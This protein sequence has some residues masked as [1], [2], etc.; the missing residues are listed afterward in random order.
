M[1]NKQSTATKEKEVE[2]EL[3]R[4]RH[5]LTLINSTHEYY[6]GYG[7]NLQINWSGDTHQAPQTDIIQPGQS[8]TRKS[9]RTN[10]A[11]FE[12]EILREKD[13]AYIRTAFFTEHVSGT[14]SGSHET[15]RLSL[16]PDPE[17]QDFVLLFRSDN[18]PAIERFPKDQW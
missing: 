6:D 12:I 17:D 11:N 13:G 8:V 5:E 15:N 16:R 2:V 14:L 18:D 10:D 1:N 4:P 3:R 9:R 7:R